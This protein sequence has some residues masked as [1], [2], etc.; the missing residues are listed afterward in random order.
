M[1]TLA[2][3]TLRD[4]S[5]ACLGAMAGIALTGFVSALAVGSGAHLPL[6]VAPIGASAVLLF[7]VPASPLAQPWSII[8]GNTISALVG[9]AVAHVIHDPALAIGVAV[10]LAIAAMSL[11]RSLHPPGGAAALTAVIGGPAVASTGFTF[12]FMPVALNSILLVGLGWCF[13]RLSRHAYPHVPAPANTHGTADP[14]PQHRVGFRAEDIDDALAD[15]GETFDIDRDDLERLLRRVELRSLIR[16]HDRLTSADIMSKDVV[17]IAPTASI[18]EAEALLLGRAIRTLPV[19]DEAN[20]LLGIVGLRELAKAGGPVG[21]VAA[22]AATAAPDDAALAL[23]QPLTDGR[24]HAVV[25]VDDDARVL[26]L[27]TQTDLLAAMA[28]LGIGAREV[29]APPFGGRLLAGAPSS[30]ASR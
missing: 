4:R 23:L 20:R 17:S 8:G 22:A 5:I 7:A 1:P 28:R 16:A 24:T 19:V 29:D 27:V 12:A 10:G 6:I 30:A 25:I 11:T 3:A 15:M 9:I 18:A 21:N 14:P 26:G 2:G 13:H